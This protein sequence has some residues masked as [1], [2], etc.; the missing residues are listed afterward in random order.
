[1]L[2]TP[3]FRCRRFLSADAARCCRHY[4]DDFFCR[5]GLPLPH[6]HCAAALFS[7]RRVSLSPLFIISL[8]PLSLRF[9]TM[10]FAIFRR[11]LRPMPFTRLPPFTRMRQRAA[12][13]DTPLPPFFAI[14]PRW[15]PR[16]C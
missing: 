4:A 11:L 9:A 16:H 7:P 15:L 1:M 10:F 12:D 13:D 2:I 8:M 6:R 5:Y 14:S 3:R